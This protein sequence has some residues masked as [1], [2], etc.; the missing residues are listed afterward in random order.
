MGVAAVGH[1]GRTHRAQGQQG[2]REAGPLDLVGQ[3]ELV[4]GRPA[5]ASELRGPA[6]AQPTVAAKLAQGG[7]VQR[8]AT[9]GVVQLLVEL[10]RHE[11]RHVQP[12]LLP[13]G[14]LV[15]CEVDVHEK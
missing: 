14:L 8:T 6:Q 1:D 5:L 4:D 9:V 11:L 13:Q 12:D 10:R 15:V 3:Q 7:G 2:Q